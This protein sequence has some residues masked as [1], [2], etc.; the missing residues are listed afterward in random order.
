MTTAEQIVGLADRIR[1]ELFRASDYYNHT[2]VVWRLA[3]RVV[4]S[5]HPTVINNVDT[6]SVTQGHELAGLAQGY[7]TGYLAESVLQQYVALFEDYVFGLIGLWLEAHPK[8]IV[9]LG[10]DA[11]DA[12]LRS[13][14][15]FI[16]LAFVTDNPDRESILRAVIA[17]ELDRL[18][19]RRPAAWFQYL[20]GRAKLGVPTA[21]QIEQLAEVKACRDVLV[22]NRGVA[23]A[24]YRNKAGA[25]ARAAEGVRL[26]VTDP[27]LRDSWSLILKVVQETSAAALAKLT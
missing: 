7:L 13:A 25:K 15:K 19:Y 21:D 2:R 20:E 12:K 8:G 4:G 10:D 17:Q 18:K 14:D 22:H 23:N 11:D 5:D 3:E 26:E 1:D 27:Y 16:P 6:G 9:G 24:T